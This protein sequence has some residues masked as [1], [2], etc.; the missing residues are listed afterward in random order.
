MTAH[1]RKGIAGDWRNHFSDELK[2]DFKERWGDL[3]IATGYERDL[4]W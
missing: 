4:D 1:Q 3:L 2:G